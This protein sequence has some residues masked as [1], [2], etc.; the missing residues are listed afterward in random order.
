[1]GVLKQLST[2]T[3]RGLCG[4]LPPQV[5]NGDPTTTPSTELRVRTSL[6]RAD[7][8]AVRVRK[9]RDSSCTNE[10][11]MLNWTKATVGT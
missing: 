7:V 3:L 11:N 8:R 6:G 1:M 9:A 2:G 10:W 4:L 5:G